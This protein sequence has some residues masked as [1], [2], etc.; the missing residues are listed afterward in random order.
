MLSQQL[1]ELVNEKLITRTVFPVIPPK[2]EYEVTEHGKSLD[3][4]LKTLSVWG[5]KHMSLKRTSDYR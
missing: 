3:T 5:E 1:K 2:V 4:V